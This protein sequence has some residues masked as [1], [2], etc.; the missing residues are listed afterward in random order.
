[1]QNK[2]NLNPVPMKNQTNPNPSGACPGLDP[3]WQEMQNKA[4]Y[5]HFQSNIADFRKKQTQFKPKKLSEAKSAA[6]QENK[7][8]LNTFLI[9]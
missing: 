2:A 9:L 1:M 8:N 7:A 3:G 4:K 6:T 5:P